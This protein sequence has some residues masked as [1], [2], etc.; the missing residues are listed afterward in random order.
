MIGGSLGGVKP[1]QDQQ[2]AGTSSNQNLLYPGLNLTGSNPGEMENTSL[3]PFL[4]PAMPNQNFNGLI[5]PLGNLNQQFGSFPVNASNQGQ[6]TNAQGYLPSAFM[7]QQLYNM[8][9]SNN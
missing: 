8:Q 7:Q 5:N 3:T 4:K 6:Q 9:N 2:N 1:I